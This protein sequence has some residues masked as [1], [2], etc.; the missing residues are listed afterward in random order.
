[1]EDVIM[2]FIKNEKFEKEQWGTTT[3]VVECMSGYFEKDTKVK[4]IGVSPRGYD[5][6]DEYGNKI[7]ETGFCSFKPI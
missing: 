6:E 1:M 7:Y 5:L 2:A 4:I 3:K